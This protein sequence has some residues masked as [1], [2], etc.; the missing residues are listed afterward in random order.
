MSKSKLKRL[1]AF[2]LAFSMAFSLIGNNLVFAY[3]KNYEIYVAPN[4]HIDTAWGWPIEE[5]AR[6][7]IPDTYK[8][9][10]KALEHSP[11]Y[12]FSTSAS[13]HYEWAKE[14]Y[15]DIYEEIKSFINKGQW[16]VVGGQVVEPDLNLAGGEALVRQSLHGQKFFEKEFGRINKTGFVPDVFGFSSQM[17]QILS[18]SGME[19]FVTTKLNWNDTNKLSG[20]IWWWQGLDG[21]KVLFYKPMLDY[22][23][24]SFSP[25]QADQMLDRI[26][27]AGV[28]R[29]F[30]LFGSGDHGGGP[31]LTGTS[32]NYNVIAG[33]DENP[34]YGPKIKISTVDEYFDTVRNDDLSNVPIIDGEMYFEYHRGTYTSWSRVKEYNRKNEILAEEAEK[35]DTIGKWLG[36]IPGSPELIK[37]AWDKILINQMHD[38]LPGSS[39]PYQYDVTF[40]QQELVKNI[41]DN[42]GNY[43]LQAI[44]Y[45]A[46]TN[47]EHGEPIFVFNPL[48]WARSDFVESKLQ[49]DTEINYIKIYDGDGNEV[50]CTVLGREGNTATTRFMAK[51]IPSMGFKVFTAVNSNEPSGLK[52]VLNVTDDYNME[53][54]FYKIIINPE[55]GNISHIYNKKDSNR[56]VLNGEGNELHIYTDTGG[57]SWPAWDVIESELNKEPTYVLN[58]TP[59]SIEIVENTPT[60]SVIRVTRNWSNSKFVQDITMYP[61]IDRIDVK[62]AVD[63]HETNKLLKVSFPLAAI[64]H[65]ATYE[66]GYGAVERPTTRDDAYGRARFEVPGH[67][68][69][70]VTN[71]GDHAFG[72]SIL[73]DS[74]YGWD[75]LLLK[76]DEGNPKATRLRLTLLR[77]AR[78][79][80][81]GSEW[82]PTS[83]P[84]VDQGF[85]EFTYSIYPHAGDWAEANTVRKAHELN[86]PVTAFQID[87][88]EGSLGNENSFI[89]VDS[90]NIIVSVVKT[91]WDDPN[92]KDIIVRLYEAHGKE[93][94]TAAI[95]FPSNVKSAT[96]VNLLEEPVSDAKPVNI[97]GNRVTTDFDKFEIKTLRVSLEDFKDNPVIQATA[98]VDLYTYFNMDGVSSNENRRDGD[99]DGKGNTYPAELWP[100]KFT[101]QGVPFVLGPTADGY[102]NLI[103]AKG[104]T[105]SLP[106]GNY[107]YVYLVGSAAEGSGETSGTFQVKY[108]DDTTI[109]KDITFAEWNAKLSGWDRF[110]REYTMPKVKDNVACIFTHYHM[111]N[112]DRMTEDNY[113]YLYKIMLDPTKTVK[114]ITLPNAPDIMIAAISLANSEFLKTAQ[115]EDG[116]FIDN[117]PPTQVKNVKAT[118]LQD[119][120]Q[121]VEINWDEAKDNDKIICYEIY[122]GINPNFIPSKD[123]QIGIVTGTVNTYTDKLIHS[124][125]YY[126][127]IIAKDPSGNASDASECSNPVEFEFDNACLMPGINVT[128]IGST[129]ANE[130]P[131]K[132]CDGTV[133]NNSKWCYNGGSRNASESNPYWL[134]VDLGEDNYSNWEINSFVVKHAQAGGESASYNT[135]DFK[136]Q[137]SNDGQ[138]WEDKVTVTGN[139]EAITIHKL[140]TP[141]TAR[142]LRLRITNPGQQNCAR[143]YEFEA[144]GKYKGQKMPSA[145]DIYLNVEK[146]NSNILI[147]PNYTFKPWDSTA[148]EMGST[149]KWYGK[150]LDDEEYTEIPGA[151]QKIL[152]LSL[153]DI[154][155]ESVI[156]EVTPKDNHNNQG[157]P[158][159]SIPLFIGANTVADRV[160]KR[161]CNA[162]GWANDAE[163]PWMAVDGDELT[164]W[165]CIGEDPHTLLVDMGGIYSLNEFEIKHAQSIGKHDP[166]NFDNDEIFNTRDFEIALSYDGINWKDPVVAVEGNNEAITSHEV[167]DNVDLDL[168]V[169]RYVRLKIIKSVDTSADTDLAYECARIYDFKAFGTPNFDVDIGPGIPG[170]EEPIDIKASNV[171]I[172]GTPEVMQVLTGSYTLDEQYEKYCRFR[173]L[174]QDDQ[175]G[176]WIPIPYAYSKTFTPTKEYEGKSIRFEVRVG[177]GEAVQSDP[178]TINPESEINVLQNYVKITANRENIDYKA[179]MVL[180]DDDATYWFAE[181]NENTL[182]IELDSIYSINRFAIKHAATIPEFRGLSALNTK[183]FSILVSTNGTDWEEAA[184]AKSNPYDVS[185]I[186]LDAP[187]MAKYV[188]LYI[189][190]S[191]YSDL[192][193]V[194]A[195]TRINEFAAY[196]T[197]GRVSVPE[198][199]SVTISSEAETGKLL[200]ADYRYNDPEGVWEGNS[201]LQ[202]MVLDEEA[203]YVPIPGA[204]TRF[205][206]PTKDLVGKY[207]KFTVIPVNKYGVRGL[208]A[209]SNVVQVQNARPQIENIQIEGDSSVKGK[210][211]VLYRYYDAEDDKEGNTTYQWY[212]SED[213][214]NFVPISGQTSA[215]L[216]VSD[217]SDIKPGITAVKC[218]I[219]PYQADGIAGKAADSKAVIITPEGYNVIKGKTVIDYSNYVNESESPAKLID[220]NYDTKWC[221]NTSANPKYVTVDLGATRLINTFILRNCKTREPGYANTRSFR[222]QVSLDNENWIN[223]YKTT[224]NTDN[225]TVVELDEPASARYIRL[226]LDESST[227]RIYELEAWGLIQGT[228]LEL[229]P[230]RQVI[231]SGELFTVKYGISVTDSVYKEDIIISY[232]PDVFTFNEETVTTVQEDTV[233][234]SVYDDGKG[235]IEISLEHLDVD[236]KGNRNVIKLGFKSKSILEADEI[237]SNISLNRALFTRY[238]GKIVEADLA[239][240]KLTVM[241]SK[242][243][244][245]ALVE[246]AKLIHESA[247]VGIENGMHFKASVDE[248]SARIIEAENLLNEGGEDYLEMKNKLSEAINDFLSRV[249]TDLTGDQ[250]GDNIIDIKD[251]DVIKMYYG[252]RSLD[253]EGSE[254]LADVDYDG[255]VGITDLAFVAGRCIRVNK[256]N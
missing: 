247:E 128:A 113:L 60:K 47:T 233:I 210:L 240:L 138:N 254:K 51:D 150:S 101:L 212:K 175:I 204:T 112:A 194:P 83:Y 114:E 89:S 192:Q 203:G 20:D 22:S 55:T 49:F 252:M 108:S 250:N 238:D 163:G 82:Q 120:V 199:I 1:F 19:N 46:N 154:T 132:A 224:S 21:S 32:N 87:E 206:R 225:I 44:A 170:E 143:I 70:D 256:N 200:V 197:S 245:L 72:A 95:T 86:Y 52:P 211:T 158:T 148:V 195:G 186:I 90:P 142:Y 193:G 106:G 172:I 182:T 58:D 222:I 184:T 180:D 130:A 26:Q 25:T 24:G 226:M 164:K 28:K 140:D 207:I 135:R 162:D 30:A 161:P 104:Q 81:S 179:E 97:S 74:K 116:A 253:L 102:N 141:V 236:F 227:A 235:K 29:A 223:V 165:C 7:V 117:E 67:K 50:P 174:Q 169:G 234:N 103:Q 121:E 213:E 237:E 76:D 3:D 63:W 41:L 244:L 185:N 232:D 13:Q 159:Q 209:S 188:R 205:L 36:V 6:D 38:I 53:N 246:D 80:S 166:N 98:F 92:S 15:P 176:T 42:V 122:R 216:N 16:N 56:D 145:T 153:A 146:D 23:M 39:V 71:E 37:T 35:L 136:I 2:A 91:L 183:N 45:K 111:P 255:K 8:K 31:L 202:W 173:W 84:Q 33:Y 119:L 155:Y 201:I 215:V 11:D 181:G 149:Y 231:N 178:V 93:H 229:D 59:D 48:S 152:T 220:G 118:L 79:H 157:K 34:A 156:F 105:I 137:T 124:G 248:L 14:Y 126:Y 167:A 57:G 160:Y 168:T 196:G 189:S 109:E 69:A 115:L 191:Y 242:N 198:I 43:G 9:A 110:A 147:T 131:W 134:T 77:S 99:L 177:L 5:T 27:S 94:T 127:K 133:E 68:W 125:T 61:D 144:W 251:L 18:K 228:T 107:K 64:A 239:S 129:G 208:I 171:S 139:T 40:N 12:K 217:V 78:T 187:I 249:I 190:E 75:A 214:V 10:L 241:S 151:T 230:P 88:H 73:N 17:P 100:T 65:N 66:T 243:A 218:R 221:D 54:K 4:S 96:E 85:Y 219:T 123:N 62:M